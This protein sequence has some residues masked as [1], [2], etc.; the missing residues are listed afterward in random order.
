MVFADSCRSLQIYLWFSVPL[1]SALCSTAMSRVRL[2]EL[3]TR[4]LVGKFPFWQLKWN[5][6]YKVCRTD[7]LG[8]NVRQNDR[9]TCNVEWRI[10]EIRWM[11]DRLVPKFKMVTRLVDIFVAYL[12]ISL[13][14]FIVGVI[15]NFFTIW[16]PRSL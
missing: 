11:L 15:L 16:S 14:P 8:S 2:G 10:E 9:Q 5:W 3:C 1:F 13:T 7:R 12:E 6:C 4:C